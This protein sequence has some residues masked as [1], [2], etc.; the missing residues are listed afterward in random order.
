[1]KRRKIG[2]G[3]GG[4]GKEIGKVSQGGKHIRMHVCISAAAGGRVC[5]RRRALAFLAKLRE[6]TRGW[7]H[8]ARFRFLLFSFCPFISMP[9][10]LV[11]LALSAMFANSRRGR[12]HS[13]HEQ[14][15]F[16]F[17]QGI[18]SACGK[19]FLRGLNFLNFSDMYFSSASRDSE[20]SKGR[21]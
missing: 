13:A 18:N 4:G 17:F 6:R 20:G 5:A 11:S 1:M 14:K 16:R 8:I 21:E 9:C 2:G 12:F 19:D 10:L 7:L 15:R 3:G